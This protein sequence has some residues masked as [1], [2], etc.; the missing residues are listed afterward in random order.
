MSSRL[1]IN[2]LL[3]VFEADGT[4]RLNIQCNCNVTVIIYECIVYAIFDGPGHSI[5]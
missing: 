2:N 5:L 1:M 4:R 3:L